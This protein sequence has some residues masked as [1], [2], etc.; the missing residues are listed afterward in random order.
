M[1]QEAVN[2]I[3]QALIAAQQRRIEQF[4]LNQQNQQFQTQQANEVAGRQADIDARN[5]ALD[6]AEEHFNVTTKAAQALHNLQLFQARMQAQQ[7]LSGPA[8][9]GASLGT[10]VAG[11]KLVGTSGNDADSTS[12]TNTWQLP[13]ELGSNPDGSPLTVNAPSFEAL[14][15]QENAAKANETN[16]AHQWE[17]DRDNVKKGWDD[18]RT[19][20]TIDAENQRAANRNAVDM[21]IARLKTSNNNPFGDGNPSNPNQNDP[22]Q[23]LQTYVH[24]LA[25]GTYTADDINK[26]FSKNK[27]AAQLVLTTAAQSGV[28]PLNKDQQNA[29]KIVSQ[30]VPNISKFD[31]Y[32]SQIPNTTNTIASHVWGL[33][34]AGNSTLNT[35]ENEF[36]NLLPDMSRMFGDKGRLAL[37]QMRYTQAGSSPSKFLPKAANVEKRN[38]FAASINNYLDSQLNNI[39]APQRALFKQK[40]GLTNIPMLNPDGSPQIQ[41]PGKIGPGGLNDQMINDMLQKHNLLPGNQSNNQPGGDND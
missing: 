1:A 12:G 6:Q 24:G 17:I 16:A 36:D 7:Q 9:A 3:I 25:D 13:P 37:Q 8:A 28:V 27:N 32:L 11:A 39:P 26:T 4:R 18:A 40:V 41:S 23:A 34:N 35:T 10:N 38:N 33:A 31:D 30:L 2:G 21:A 20:A 15:A 19:K 5:K 29:L 14:T 22:Q